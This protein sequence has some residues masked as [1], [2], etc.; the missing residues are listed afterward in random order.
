MFKKVTFKTVIL[1]IPNEVLDYLKSD[2][3][4]ILPKECN[5]DT[6]EEES[7]S[8]ENELPSFPEFNAKLKEAI[9]RLGGTVFPKLNWSAPRDAA[10]VG[11]GHSL[12]CDSLTQIW[13]L[14]KS[15]DFICHDLI[16]PFKD[17]V[18][19]HDKS[20]R[21]VNYV[22]ALKKWHKDINPATEFRLEWSLFY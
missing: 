20:Q 15:S 10:W 18:D 2:G 16:Q 12:K 14:L 13:I 8:N 1:P 3:T 11:V 21:Q 5:E 6:D 17:C 19:G 4:L 9:S 22:M 7:S